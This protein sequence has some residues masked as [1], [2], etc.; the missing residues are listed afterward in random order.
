MKIIEKFQ[1]KINGSLS[2][3]D[4]MIIK[5]HLRQFF[6]PSGK[7]HYLS[8][9]NVLLKD[10][11]EYAKGV[12]TKIKEHVEKMAEERERP[13]IYL[14]S[15]KISK[16]ETAMDILKK[17]SIEEG[18]ICVIST[19]E[20]CKSVDVKKNNKT[21]KLELQND[22]R[23]CLYYYFYYLDRECGFMHIRLQTW[24]PF[25]IQVYINGREYI[26]KQLDKLGIK[27]KRYDNSFT[28]IDDI[29][30]AQEISDSFY[31]KDLNNMLNHF[32]K[33]VNAYLSRIEEIFHH[34]YY[35]C[36]DQCEYATDIMFKSRK[37]LQNVYNDLVKHALL[38]FNC[39]DVM[40]FM[41]RKMHPAFSGEVVSDLKKRPQG[42]RIK[43]RMASNSIKMYDKYSVLRVETTINDPKNF[44]IFKKTGQD[45]VKRWVPMGKSIANLYRYAQVSQAANKR[46]LDAVSLAEPRTESIAEVEQICNK[47]TSGKRTFSGMNPVS[48]E[49]E[50]IFLAVMDG[51]NHINGF[52][53]ASVRTK[54]FPEAAID[55][56]AV[57]NKTTRIIA[58]L[59][60][61]KLIAKIPH[62]F[63]YK[64]TPKGIRIMSSVLTVKNIAL[65]DAMKTAS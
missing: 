50:R 28:E 2:G 47:V 62:S 9:E 17:E 38:S 65:P 33:E 24:F 7:R 16:E 10:F 61:H 4:R 37:D 14:N 59:R 64:V 12:T 39:E 32:A 5:G 57:R 49:T 18:L 56:K 43:H 52:T 15:P 42:F 41:G 54:L 40:I 26:S 51:G 21:Q 45:Q 44:K 53:N 55:D 58:K 34:G 48:K 20:L 23:K 60:A 31:G 30:K 11:G 8:Q 46:Y 13:L 1:D 63:R 27:Y 35:W 29:Q 25:E 3:Y 36:L 19:V 6:S 22:W